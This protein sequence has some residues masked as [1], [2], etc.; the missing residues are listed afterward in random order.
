MLHIKKFLTTVRNVI[1]GNDAF[2]V[3]NEESYNI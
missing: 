2:E 1:A 3:L